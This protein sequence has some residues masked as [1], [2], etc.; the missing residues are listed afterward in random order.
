[1]TNFNHSDKGV[2]SAT[3]RP[4]TTRGVVMRRVQYDHPLGTFWGT[5]QR[6]TEFQGSD[7][8]YHIRCETDNAL[9]VVQGSKLRKDT[10]IASHVKGGV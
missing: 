7:V 4:A 9:H 10:D 6:V 1:M 8:V 5:I 3:V 2:F